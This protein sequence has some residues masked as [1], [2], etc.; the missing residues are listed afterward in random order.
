M[1]TVVDPDAELHEVVQFLGPI[2]FAEFILDGILETSVELVGQCR[3]V[4]RY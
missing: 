1:Q 3:V 4:P 2:D